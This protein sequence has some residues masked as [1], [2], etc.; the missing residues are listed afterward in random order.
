MN[1]KEFA[2]KFSDEIKNVLK[3]LSNG[4]VRLSSFTTDEYNDKNR[5]FANF[6][7]YDDVFVDLEYYREKKEDK[8]VKLTLEIT[9]SNEVIIQKLIERFEDN[10]TKDGE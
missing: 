4:G 9:T 7:D 8:T 5:I 10:F 1:K 6:R 3:N 2:N